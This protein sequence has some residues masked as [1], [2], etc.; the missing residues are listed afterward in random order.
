MRKKVN[1]VKYLVCETVK[2]YHLIDIDEE[3]D[4][5]NVVN[6]AFDNVESFDN[7][8]EA[9]KEELSK[10]DVL[11]GFRFDIKPDFGGPETVSMTITEE[12]D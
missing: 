3:L 4:A 8:V 10:Y 2:H 6:E 7:G 1:K 12:M 11:Y 9:V 5:E